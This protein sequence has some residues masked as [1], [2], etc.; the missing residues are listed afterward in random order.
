[1][2]EILREPE[3]FGPLDEQESGSF[4]ATITDD[5]GTMLPGSLLTA[6][7]LTLY[8][9][10][11]SGVV[12]TINNRDH[13]NVLNTNN[14]EVFDVLQSLPDGRTY[15]LR[16]R[17]QPEDTTLVEA[18]AYESHL[19]LFEWSWNSGKGKQEGVLVVKNLT[20]VA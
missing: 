5:L 4:I 17:I 7:A 19:F 18:L 20:V 2:A 11:T 3:R 10:R 9:I 1:M 12:T 16:W 13:Q 15:N 14:V 6:L 8:V